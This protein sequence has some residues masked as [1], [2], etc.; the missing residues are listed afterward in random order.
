MLRKTQNPVYDED[1]TFFGINPNQLQTTVLHFVILSF[2]RYSRDDVIGEVFCQL[3]LL[4]FDSLEKQIFLTKDICVRSHK[5]MRL[6][7]ALVMHNVI[8]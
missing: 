5:V 2:D 3:N 7:F 1:F 4:E 8:N 6:L